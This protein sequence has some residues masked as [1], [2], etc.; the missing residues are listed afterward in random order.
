[1]GPYAWLIECC[2]NCGVDEIAQIAV[3]SVSIITFTMRNC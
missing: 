2:S 1:M 3:A